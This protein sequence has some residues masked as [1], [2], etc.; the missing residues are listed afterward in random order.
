M[1]IGNI[2]PGC[3]NGQDCN[4]GG[5]PR[6]QYLEGFCL[7]CW[8]SLTPGQRETATWAGNIDR[9]AARVEAL[10]ADTQPT[11]DW[12]VIELL[13]ALEAMATFDGDRPWL[14]AA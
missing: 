13:N 7:M 2:Y 11:E 12:E 8:A 5:Q 10:E 4:K 6:P 14:D 1:P 3:I 9:E